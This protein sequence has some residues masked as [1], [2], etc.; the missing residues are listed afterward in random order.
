MLSSSQ[1]IDNSA[2][3]HANSQKIAILE[4]PL[5]A[6]PAVG[7]ADITI[8]DESA[9]EYESDSGTD[10]Y[11]SDQISTYVVHQ[12]DTLSQIAKMFNVSVNTI[13]WANDIKNGAISPGDTLVILP[14][15]GIQYK[16]KSGD[17]IPTIAKKYNADANE[18]VQYNGLTED[19]QLAVGDEIIIPNAEVAQ[20]AKTTSSG[21]TNKLKTNYKNAIPGYFIRPISGGSRSQ[22]LHGFNGV[23]LAAPVGT[24]IMASASGHVIVAKNNGG[25]NGG[26][27]NYIVIAHPN[28]TQTLYAHMRDVAVTVGQAV[29]QGNVIGHIGMT[30][31]TTGP[32]VH[33]EVRGAVNPFGL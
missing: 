1:T 28:G 24:D 9:L 29:N 11:R 32:H 17:T 20:I 7:G 3:S 19:S 6:R 26:Y 4:A 30:G 23:D 22:G 31:K 27:G 33:F 16:V 10:G 2:E 21:S 14:V 8:V 13:V 12:G 25:Y 5:S 15:S 18:I